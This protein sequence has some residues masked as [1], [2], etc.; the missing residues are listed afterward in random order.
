MPATPSSP[1]PRRSRGP[2]RRPR[3]LRRLHR[4]RLRLRQLGL[5]DP[6]GPRPARPVA[7]RS[8][9]WCCSPSRPARCSRCRCPGRWSPGSAR[10]GPS[11]RWR[12]CSAPG[13]RRSRSATRRAGAGGRRA[14]PARLRQRRLGRGD[15]RPGRGRRAPPGPLDHV[16]LPRRLQPRHGR[17]RA[18]RRRRWSRS[19]CR[20]PRTCSSW[21]SP[22][23]LVRRRRV[24][25]SC[26]TQRHRRAPATR[27]RPSRGAL[28]AWREPRTLLIGVFVLAF[29]FAEGTGNDWISVAVIDGYGTAAARRHAW[30][31]PRSWP[32]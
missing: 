3:H 21:R 27:G 22:S 19:A 7:V 9:G 16:P 32:R 15:E 8:W 4:L 17:R 20:S 12:C 13:W 31:S 25:G 1:R 10:G 14:V 18:G 28:A 26:P 23:R 29:A 6:A 30:P 24:R 5:A 11:P 2:R